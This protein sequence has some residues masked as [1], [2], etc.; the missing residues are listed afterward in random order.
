[1]AR[2]ES[3]TRNGWKEGERGHPSFIH[4]QMS[5][6]LSLNDPAASSSS[7]IHPAHSAFGSGTPSTNI[8]EA[9]SA[10][11]ISCFALGPDACDVGIDFVLWTPMSLLRKLL[12]HSSYHVYPPNRTNPNVICAKPPLHMFRPSFPFITRMERGQ[13]EQQRFADDERERA[14]KRASEGAPERSAGNI[15]KRSRPPSTFAAC[16]ANPCIP[17]QRT[18]V[19]IQSCN[20]SMR[21]H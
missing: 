8:K 21:K 4:S 12:S 15:V 19:T 16:G 5:V 3:E 1:M 2:E 7:M 14:R 11:P 13:M 20:C 9:G 6:C 17:P 10:A 18:H